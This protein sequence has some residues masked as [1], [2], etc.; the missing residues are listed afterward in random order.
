[1]EGGCR[2]GKRADG[3]SHARCYAGGQSVR[4]RQSM[5]GCGHCRGSRLRA[6]SYERA[7]LKFRVS[8]QRMDVRI[9][10]DD[11]KERTMSTRW[12][13]ICGAAGLSASAAMARDDSPSFGPGSAA[14]K[15]LLARC[16]ANS[17]AEREQCMRDAEAADEKAGRHC[18]NLTLRARDQCLA[19]ARSTQQ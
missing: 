19:D 14:H 18:D 16:K 1:R 13:V 6:R 3:T 17:Q 2:G 7:A 4:T 12:L 9:L 15:S 10:P 5:A 8:F 11:L